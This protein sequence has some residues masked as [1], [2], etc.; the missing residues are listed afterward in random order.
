MQRPKTLQQRST[1]QKILTGMSSPPVEE[2]KDPFGEIGMGEEGC[3]N[4]RG[5]SASVA[6]DTVGL[7]RAENKELKGR[8]G[9]LEEAVDGALGLCDG[10]GR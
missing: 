10:L 8:V 5:K 9:S 7:L 3:S 4:C 1:F 6:W 2:V